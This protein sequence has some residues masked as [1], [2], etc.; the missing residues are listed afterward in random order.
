MPRQVQ[1]KKNWPEVNA[2]SSV[3]TWRGSIMLPKR[4]RQQSFRTNQEYA[5]YL[6][7][8]EWKAKREAVKRRCNN[9][10]ERCRKYLV[11]EVHHLTYERLFNEL[12]EDL[13]GLCK[14]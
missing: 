10:C 1:F 7:S 8:P 2:I 9:I 13:Q 12:L 14:P 4:S 3:F 5:N 6:D 11:D